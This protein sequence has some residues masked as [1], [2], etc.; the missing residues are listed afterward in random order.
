MQRPARLVP[1][2]ALL[3][4]PREQSRNGG[5]LILADRV[6]SCGADFETVLFGELFD[7]TARVRVTQARAQRELRPL[8]CRL[9]AEAEHATGQQDP[10]DAFKYPFHRAN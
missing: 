1:E 9:D 5:S 10:A 4:E 3:D 2:V 8:E 6:L 7:V